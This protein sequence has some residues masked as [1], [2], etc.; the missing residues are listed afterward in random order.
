[1]AS[2]EPI[3]V[4]W[5][6]PVLILIILA[7]VPWYFPRGAVQPVVLGFPLW[8]FVSLMMSLLLSVFLYYVITHHWKMEK[9]PSQ[10]PES[11][12]TGGERK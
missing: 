6:W 7:G 4:K 10:E 12:R 11:Q 9:P 1:M 8:A 3:K 5:I 2:R